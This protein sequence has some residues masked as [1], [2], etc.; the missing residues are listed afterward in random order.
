M[1]RL[2]SLFILSLTLVI[3]VWALAWPIPDTGQTKCYKNTGEIVCPQPGEA[4][5]GQDANYT[6]NPPSYTKLDING[7][8]LSDDAI[9]WTMVRDNVTGMVWEVKQIKDGVADY[10]CYVTI[11]FSKI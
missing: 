5:Y 7:N 3:P 1:I 6:V 10:S 9:E 11:P 2:R 4:F 8:E